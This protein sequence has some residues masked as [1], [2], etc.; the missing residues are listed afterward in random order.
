MHFFADHVLLNFIKSIGTCNFNT[1]A[2]QAQQ[3]GRSLECS[4]VDTPLAL[5]PGHR[6]C[7]VLAAVV[8]GP[9]IRR[10]AS[11][12]HAVVLHR[13]P[14]S[15]ALFSWNKNK[16][17]LILKEVRPWFNKC[18]A[19]ALHYRPHRPTWVVTPPKVKRQT[20]TYQVRHQSQLTITGSVNVSNV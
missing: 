19:L 12:K 2:M 10:R 5:V 6:G 14:A 17:E 15:T 7:W 1:K 13:A 20:E 9:S 11:G 4:P 16:K 8:G 18:G 3:R